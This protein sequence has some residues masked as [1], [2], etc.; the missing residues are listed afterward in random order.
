MKKKITIGIMLGVT[1]L[2]A[3]IMLC[4]FTTPMFYNT[5]YTI[6][7]NGVYCGYIRVCDTD[8]V[9]YYENDTDTEPMVYQGV[10][11]GDTLTFGHYTFKIK[12]MFKLVLSSNNNCTAT[13]SGGGGG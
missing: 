4:T 6:S 8:L 3:L 12:S 1:C 2:T 7:E 11:T 10:I 5:D 9:K 13:P